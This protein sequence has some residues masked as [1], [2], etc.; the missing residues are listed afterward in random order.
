MIQPTP[1]RSMAPPPKQKEAQSSQA[2]EA[3]RAPAKAKAAKV[4]AS[5]FLMK[6]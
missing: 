6:M 2:K 1:K 5:V 4:E 3:Q